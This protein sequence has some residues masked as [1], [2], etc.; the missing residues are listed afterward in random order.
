MAEAKSKFPVKAVVGAVIILV[1]VGVSYARYQSWQN[2]R[3]GPVGRP[4]ASATQSQSELSAAD[5]AV[6]RQG[7]PLAGRRTSRLQAPEQGA[8]TADGPAI[9]P[10]QSKKRGNRKPKRKRE[11]KKDEHGIY[12]FE[13]GNIDHGKMPPPG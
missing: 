12:R 13:D 2:Q 7:K 3:M 8:E 11:S 4:A 1:L 5:P 9:D 6:Q 10:Q